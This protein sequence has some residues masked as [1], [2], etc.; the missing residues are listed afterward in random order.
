MGLGEGELFYRNDGV[1]IWRKD[2]S[3]HALPAMAGLER[4]GGRCASRVKSLDGEGPKGEV[5][6]TAGYAIHGDAIKGRE[7]AIGVQ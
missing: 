2:R 4:G 3:G 6:G 5:G 1:A 7:V